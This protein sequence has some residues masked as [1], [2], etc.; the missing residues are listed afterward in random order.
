MTKKLIDFQ[1]TVNTE[2]L[3][4]QLTKLFKDENHGAMLS[5]CITELL[6]NDE[7]KLAILFNS[8]LNINPD[9]KY[10]IGDHVLCNHSYMSTWNWERKEMEKLGLIKDNTIKGV[11]IDVNKFNPEPYIIE[12]D[13]IFSK[14]TEVEKMTESVSIKT[15]IRLLDDFVE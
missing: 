13:G 3:E 2:L 7:R 4:N 6:S 14:K 9:I 5:E 15:I 12:Y 8:I 11:I 1:V 10:Q